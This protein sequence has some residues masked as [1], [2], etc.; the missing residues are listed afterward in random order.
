MLVAFYC[1]LLEVLKSDFVEIDGQFERDATLI[2]TDAIGVWV[3]KIQLPKSADVSKTVVNL[4]GLA[5][6]VY[7]LTCQNADFQRVFKIVKQ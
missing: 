1:Q 2:L 4:N 3:Q 5:N 6:G 7:F